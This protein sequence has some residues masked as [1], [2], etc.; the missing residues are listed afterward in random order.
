[1]SSF[2]QWMR[3]FHWRAVQNGDAQRMQLA[4]LWERSVELSYERPDEK[5]AILDQAGALARRLNEPYWDL[6]FDHWKIEVLL[7]EKHRPA[8]ALKLAVRAAFEVRKPIYDAFAYRPQITLSLT[9]CYLKTDPIGYEKPLREAFEYARGQCQSDE[10]L[11]PYFAQQWSRFLEAIGAPDAVEANWQHLYASYQSGTEHYVLFALVHL[12]S[13][14]AS[15]DLPA[16]RAHIGEFSAVG[17]ELCR[18]EEREREAAVFTMWAALAARWDGD[19]EG[20]RELYRRAFDL[21]KRLASP[22]NAVGLAA[23]IYHETAG[24]WKDAL[25]VVE[26]ETEVAR[27]HELQFLQAKARLKQ[28]EL[29][30]RLGRNP[31]QAVARLREVASQLKSR[32]YWEA[33]LDE[34]ATSK[35]AVRWNFLC[36]PPTIGSAPTPTTRSRPAMARSCACA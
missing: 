3:D 12:C 32:P 20:A 7:Y 18:I 4:I 8:E 10:E 6:F 25:R 31:N 26:Q 35:W 14:L 22:H 28:I 1:M 19:E 29:L 9:A 15:Y 23:T 11:R 27:K 5:L 34:F 30:R 36:L 21:Q 33:R 13:T 24:E 2:W 16:A 17:L